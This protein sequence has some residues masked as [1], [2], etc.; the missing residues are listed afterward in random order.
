MYLGVMTIISV[1]TDDKERPMNLGLMWA[2]ISPNV[3]DI[4]S[5]NTY[6]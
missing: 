1:K 3:I 5:A 2:S 4:G 6:C